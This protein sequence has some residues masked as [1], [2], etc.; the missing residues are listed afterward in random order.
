MARLRARVG[1]ERNNLAGVALG[2]L[3][4]ELQRI[5]AT[6]CFLAGLRDRFAR[7]ADNR[8]SEILEALQDEPRCSFQ[9]GG[10]AMPG[11]RSRHRRPPLGTLKKGANVIGR[12]GSYASD[13]HAVIRI[14]NV[15]H[16]RSRGNL[17]L[18]VCHSAASLIE[19]ADAERWIA[20][21]S[22]R[23]A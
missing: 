10:P 22:E 5:H 8:A 14:E 20:M 23:R 2:F 15:D 6:R 12:A 17:K 13:N 9:N 1:V 3:R 7:F 21:I 16:F 18:D 11:E 4:R 19:P